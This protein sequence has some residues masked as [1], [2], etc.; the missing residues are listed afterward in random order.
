[1]VRCLA[2]VQELISRGVE[3]HLLTEQTSLDLFPDL[4]RHFSKVGFPHIRDHLDHKYDLLILDHP[5]I[6][7]DFEAGLREVAEKIMAFS[8]NP[9]EEIKAD[10]L[11]DS[12]FGRSQS[13]YQGLV[14]EDCMMF[15]GSDFVPMRKELLEK[16]ASIKDRILISVGFTDSANMVLRYMNSLNDVGNEIPVDVVIGYAPAVVEEL[17][18][19]QVKL[20]FPLEIFIQPDNMGEIYLRSKFVLGG[21]GSSVWERAALR[22]PSI[23]VE[24]ADNQKHLL[25]KMNEI[26][27]LMHLGEASKLRD[28]E[29]YKA[30]KFALSN[31]EKLLD[32]AEVAH[33]Y[34]DGKGAVRIVDRL[35]RC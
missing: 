32:M 17:E 2:L 16:P 11:L 13:D 6:D 14:N 35:M 30:I 28:E 4:G 22:I 3:C 5:E 19:I 33:K 25:E 8:D 26:G 18:A 27:A 23:T 24:I 12:N 29:L 21:G 34:C 7:L 31:E 15:L 10:Y 20:C 9:E 1:M